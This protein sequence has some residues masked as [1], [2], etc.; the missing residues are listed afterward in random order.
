MHLFR[1]RMVPV[2]E[3]V[4]G[5]GRISFRVSNTQVVTA[6]ASYIYVLYSRD[7]HA[8]AAHAAELSRG[9]CRSFYR[10]RTSRLAGQS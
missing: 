4:P 3:C 6:T 5:T 9:G 7:S 8:Q 10:T 2:F 1:L